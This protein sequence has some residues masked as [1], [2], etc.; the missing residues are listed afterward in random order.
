MVSI[1][2]LFT[3]TKDV[4]VKN[5]DDITATLYVKL[6][7]ESDLN[8][9]YKL[10]RIASTNRREAL[11]NKESIEYQDEILPLVDLTRE[12]LT[13]MIL[14]THKNRYMSEA[15]VKVN[16]EELP[17]IEE[18]AIEPDAPDLEEQEILDKRFDE[19]KEDY[20]RRIDEYVEDR[21]TELKATLVDKKDEEIIKFAQD[22]MANILPL[23]AFFTELLAQKGF[24]GSFV[25][26]ECKKRIFSTIEEYKGADE[27]LRKQ[28]LEAYTTLEIGADDIKN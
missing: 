1:K 10:S 13:A 6:L 17:K 28:I 24:R 12:E 9:S 18:I 21:L 7:G 4:V 23:Q 11:R 20:D 16:R 14:G 22:E 26:K 2:E 3:Y 25:D 8:E 5:R 27:S 15:F 19:Q